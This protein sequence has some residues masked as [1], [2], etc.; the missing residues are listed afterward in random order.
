MSLQS[1]EFRTLFLPR[2][3]PGRRPE[4]IGLK[5]KTHGTMTEACVVKDFARGPNGEVAAG[6]RRGAT[7]GFLLCACTGAPRLLR[8]SA[9]YATPAL[10]GRR[11]LAEAK[12]AAATGAAFSVTLA[13]PPDVV[14]ALAAGDAV[15]VAVGDVDGRAYFVLGD[16]PLNLVDRGFAPGLALVAVG[17]AAVSPRTD[18]VGDV[19]ALLADA[20]A[21]TATLR[22][23]PKYEHLLARFA[24]D[25]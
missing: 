3:P 17:D 5:L 4:T 12:A 1:W 15:N 8:M 14:V 18:A 10:V 23:V 7:V 2:S 19:A 22:D 11:V 6:E 24:T 25:D 13:P 21:K 20:D 16:Q 9:G